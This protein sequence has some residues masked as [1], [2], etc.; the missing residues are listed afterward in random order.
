MLKYFV[1]IA[2]TFVTSVGGG[3]ITEAGLD[4]YSS[5]NVPGI[6]PDAQIYG[7]A[8]TIIYLL[9]A[10]SAI[11]VWTKTLRG[12]KA[13]RRRLITYIFIA[14]A[15]LNILWTFIFFS[16]HSFEFALLEIFILNASIIAL[17]ILIWPLSR[18]AA[19]MLIPYTAWV[20]FATY[21]AYMVLISN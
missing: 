9:A 14:N 18:I 1:I 16:L 17:I 13:A 6:I 15:F 4:W 5:I 3:F 7:V 20:T 11:I 19:Y 8:W 10:T 2:I 12:K 21:L